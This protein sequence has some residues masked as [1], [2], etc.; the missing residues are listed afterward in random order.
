MGDGGSEFIRNNE[1][2]WR[3][4]SHG[5]PAE[6]L[7]IGA[8]AL[9]ISNKVE[10]SV[11]IGKSNTLRN[12]NMAKECIPKGLGDVAELNWIHSYF[13]SISLFETCELFSS[14]AKEIGLNKG[15]EK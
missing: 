13:I 15:V 5:V 14:L 2:Q 10:T 4:L 11:L 3:V 12:V 9:L 8:N 1:Y 7:A 6:S